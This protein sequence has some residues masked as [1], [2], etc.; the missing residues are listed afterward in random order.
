MS[1]ILYA[2]PKNTTRKLSTWALII[3]IAITSF[4]GGVYTGTQQE[5]QQ[6]VG[7]YFPSVVPRVAATDLSFI[8][9]PAG[10]DLTPIWKVW[11][12]LDT[13]FVPSK[14]PKPDDKPVTTEDRI[15]G[16]A[17]GLAAAQG[18]PY[19]AFFPPAENEQFKDD[20]AGS[21]EGVGM[22]IAVRDGVL[23]VVAPLKDTPSYKAGVLAQDIITKIDDRDTKGMDV[24]T[25][26][27]YIRGPKGTKVKI[28]V[29]REGLADEKVIEITRDV[30]QSPII[31]TEKRKDGIFVIEFYSFAETSP[32]LF[33]QALLEFEKSGYSKLIVDMR[34]NPGGYLE[35]AVDIA[36]WFLPA[37]AVVVTEDYAGKQDAIVHRS[38]GYNAFTDKLQLVVLV[39]KGSASA[40]EILTGALKHYKKAT[41]IGTNTFGKGSVQELID[42]TPTTSLKVTV[43][44]WLMPD[45]GW[46][47]GTGVEP[48]IKVTLP[49][50]PKPLVDKKGNKIPA[51]DIIMQRALQFFKTGK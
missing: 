30:I 24:R 13:K 35:A 44:R 9:Q 10:A 46:I 1:E 23:M 29:L 19:T 39:D 49:K 20:I 17:A 40:S 27:K 18:D 45:G 28:T 31:K 14:V 48:N 11:Q 32:E 22:E 33:R 43:A 21:F 36:S 16:M 37:G 41:V 42:I 7:S 8:G 4:G 38:K 51:N 50:E 2:M 3:L 6:V 12:A 34:G 15:Y 47:T 26:V 25:A 5:T